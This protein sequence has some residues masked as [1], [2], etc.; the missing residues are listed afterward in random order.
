M[1]L[2]K[3]KIRTTYPR[4]VTLIISNDTLIFSNELNT[5]KIILNLYILDYIFGESVTLLQYAISICLIEIHV[6]AE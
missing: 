6:T 4:K 3:Y 1:V 5:S 2:G